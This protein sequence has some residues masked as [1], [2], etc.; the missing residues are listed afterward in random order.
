MRLVSLT[1]CE[2]QSDNHAH[3]LIH[4][5]SNHE[6][7]RITGVTTLIPKE[8]GESQ[9]Q[10]QSE[11][12][13]YNFVQVSRNYLKEW[14]L[15]MRKSPLASEVL[16][17]L[18]EHMG[19]TTNAV[20]CSYTTLTEATGVSRASVARALKLLKED[21]WIDSVKIGNATAYAV[22][23]RVF[24][25]AGRHQKQ[26]AIFQA[27]VIASGTEQDSDFKLKAKQSIRHIPFIE[28]NARLMVDNSELLSPPD[29]QDL[30]LQ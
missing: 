9:A 24:W 17:F 6:T 22:N 19:R 8:T 10:D 15:L 16:M 12:D 13:N 7:S 5:V 18:V 29:Q 2:T 23:A 25:Q 28:E 26:Y 14:R 3:C 27:T 11:T 21:N 4:S 30:D 20:V 1:S